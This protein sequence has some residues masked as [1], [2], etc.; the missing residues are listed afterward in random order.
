MGLGPANSTN[1]EEDA[2]DRHVATPVLPGFTMSAEW[3]EEDAS[4]T[5]GGKS[6]WHLV[7]VLQAK[8]LVASRW[9]EARAGV[10]RA[11][12][13]MF[14]RLLKAA[15]L[16]PVGEIRGEVWNEQAAWG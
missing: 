16:Q 13:S 6:W 5:S 11:K 4:F 7:G 9:Q 12:W 1:R 3:K 10:E 2:I 15:L 14:P 8:S